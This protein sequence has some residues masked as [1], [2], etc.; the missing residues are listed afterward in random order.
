MDVFGTVV[1]A[2]NLAAKLV[3][4]LQA[5]KGAK[6]DR[7]RLLPEISALGAL[8]Q[9][10]R[11]RLGNP[12]AN[13]TGGG[14]QDTVTRLER[15]VLDT[16]AGKSLS[17]TEK[18]KDIRWPFRQGEIRTMLDWVERLKSLVSL[19]FQTSLME[20][21]EK[22]HDELAAVGLNVAGL[23]PLSQPSRQIRETESLHVDLQ[24]LGWTLRDSANSITRI[25]STVAMIDRNQQ[26]QALQGPQVALI[27]RLQWKA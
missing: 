17:L 25:E 21:I 6:E 18:M 4:Y 1:G 3:G 7:R 19:A 10:L 24:A 16:D 2:I 14:L 11:G 27:T 26:D 8:L 15:L 12:P 20:F 5:V 9:V 23:S 13:G 22:A